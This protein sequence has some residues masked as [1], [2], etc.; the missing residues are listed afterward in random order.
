MLVERARREEELIEI[1]EEILPLT[2]DN[3][4]EDVI[5]ILRYILVKDIGEE[6]AKEYIKKLEEGVIEMSGY[7]NYLRQDREATML[8]MRNEGKIQEAIRVAK[9]MLKEKIDLNLIEKITGLKRSQFM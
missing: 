6:K 2:K 3:E 1:L 8:K 4:R 5:N 7:V 9:N